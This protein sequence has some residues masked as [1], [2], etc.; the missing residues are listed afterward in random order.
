MSI[1]YFNEMIYKQNETTKFLRI[2]IFS[3]LMFVLLK[4]A[5]TQKNIKKQIKKFNFNKNNNN[6][7]NN[8]KLKDM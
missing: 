3:F 1:N 4:N 2:L 8:N 5:T 7:N 6:N